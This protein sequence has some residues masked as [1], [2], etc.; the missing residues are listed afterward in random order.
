MGSEGCGK[1]TV[2]KYQDEPF[3][4]LLEL[5]EINPGYFKNPPSFGIKD[6]AGCCKSP[7]LVETNPDRTSVC[8]KL[9]T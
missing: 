2:A 1:T 9:W 5:A 4:F 3:N 8:S 7:R 6:R